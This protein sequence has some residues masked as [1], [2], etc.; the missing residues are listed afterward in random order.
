[1]A[2]V[3]SDAIWPCGCW[4]T[5]VQVMACCMT[6]MACCMTALS[7]YLSFNQFSGMV[8]KTPGTYYN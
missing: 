8:N 3:A 2:L 4:S 5:L 6:V 7:L 1:M